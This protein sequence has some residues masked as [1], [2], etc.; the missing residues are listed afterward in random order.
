MVK[1]ALRPE[2]AAILFALAPLPLPRASEPGTETLANGLVALEFRAGRLSRV[3]DESLGAALDVSDE[4]E[5]VSFSGSELSTAGLSPLETH[6]REG[7][8]RFAYEAG[9]RRLEVAYELRPGWRFAAKRLVLPL[10]AGEAG[11]VER[12]EALRAR[13]GARVAA[14]RR[15]A[16]GSR[17]AFLRFAEEVRGDAGRRG[18]LGAFFV[19]QN[20][21][22]EWRREEGRISLAYAP[23]MEWREAYGPFESDRACFGLYRA[24][25]FEIPA[26]PLPE[27]QYVPDPEKAFEGIPR[28]DLAELDA[29]SGCVAEFLVRRPARS[30]KVHVPWCENDYQIDAGT[31][32]GRAE[33]RRIIDRAAD[34]GCEHALFT[35]ANSEVSRVEDNAD[36]W[37]WENVLWFGLGQKIRKGEWDPRRDPVPASIQEMLQHAKARG[38]RLV[39]YVYPSLG[40]LQDPEWTR[41]TGGKVGGY[42]GADTGVR[43][44]QDWL[45]A[46]LV[47]FAERTGAGGFS[48]DHWWI[49]YD[50][51]S[52]KYAQWYGCR[53]I[54]AELRRRLPDAVVDGRQQYQWFGPWTWIGG[55]YPHPTTND[56]QPQSFENFPDLHFDRVSANRQRWAAYTYRVEQFAPVELVPGYMTHQTQRYDRSGALRRDRFRPRD[57]D[58]LGWKYSVISSVGTAPFHHVVNMIPARDEDEHRLFPK[59]DA[60]W[61]R[62]WLSFSDA[63]A[64][65][66]RKLRP[67]I[68]PPA[69]GRVDGTAAAD[70]DRGFV[71]LYNPNCRPL[72]AEFALDGSI[73]I[74]RGERFLLRELYPF[75]GRLRGRPGTGFWERGERVSLEIRGPEALVLEIAPERA[76]GLPALLGVPGRAELSGG[77]LRVEGA[78]GEV[79]TAVELSVLVPAGSAVR[80]LFVNGVRW[81]RFEIRRD[82]I[83]ARVRF[84]GEPFGRSQAVLP[85][86]P[87]FRG[88]ARRASFRIPRR[89]SSQL[90]ARKKAWPIPYDADD[91][92]ATWLGSDRLLLFAQIAD[93]KDS[94]DVSLAIDGKPVEVRKAYGSV[95]PQVAERTFLGF[96]ADVSA[97]EPETAHELELVLPA[98]ERGQFQGL[99]FEN[100]EPEFTSEVA[101]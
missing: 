32:E 100:V 14:E 76:V 44:F 17:G 10:R 92:E 65:I 96:Y 7:E 40:F 75:E 64:E 16:D 4:A 19:L 90:E 37:G 6:R 49:A 81:P 74:S 55:S 86:D 85:H 36:A 9:G 98:L 26:R 57:W 61:F 29:L 88:G 20:P 80:S 5:A 18:L 42:A 52:S 53:R 99:F 27:W 34:V 46:E 28:I 47:A 94:W 67:I 62:R 101:P 89:V 82:V 39:A 38:V 23:E 15:V 73:G 30:V 1:N 22:L 21:F 66:L 2:I 84:A 8:L 3:R 24:S 63:N 68:G 77:E 72:T 45:L 60:A 41:W 91:L 48:F 12:V 11:R 25:G 70:G 59:E 51:A 87:E 13:P 35:A 33:Y 71:F 54:L 93:P 78:R 43:S 79:G 95:Y 50:G 83:S 69:V 56:E 31:P 58:L 97:L